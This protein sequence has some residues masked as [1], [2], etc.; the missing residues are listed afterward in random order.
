MVDESSF[1][2]D[3]VDDSLAEE[4]IDDFNDALSQLLQAGVPVSKFSLCLDFECRTGVPLYALL[5]ERATGIDIDTLRRCSDLLDRCVDWDQEIDDVVTSCV[6]AGECVDSW[7]LGYL[8]MRSGDCF[9][10]CLACSTAGRR[11]LLSVVAGDASAEVFILVEPSDLVDF[12]QLVLRRERVASEGFFAIA[13]RAFPQLVF[14]SELDF[15]R[16]H[17]TYD[18]VYDW[19]VEVLAVLNNRMVQSFESR[20]GVRHLVQSDMASC[21]VDVSPESSQTH[22]NKKAIAQRSVEHDGQIYLCEWHAKRLWNTDRIHFTT[23]GS[24]PHGR[25]LIGLFVKHLDT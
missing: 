6:V 7:S 12:W 4:A 15:R 18:E 1:A 3:S 25:I 24:L 19:V 22:K 21:G 2:F 14:H 5:Y 9:M 16:F 8:V 17:G 23:P 20:K 11:G 10:A 13:D